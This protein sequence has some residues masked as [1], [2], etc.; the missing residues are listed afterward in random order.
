MSEPET[1][2]DGRYIVVDGRRWRATDPTIP[3]NLRVELVKALM[4]ARRRV[5]SDGQ[6]ARAW[7]HDAKMALGERGDP[8]WEPTEDGRRTRIGAV[9][10]TLLRARPEGT[11]CPSEAARVVGADSWREYMSLARDV[12]WAGTADGSLVVLQRGE[13]VTDP[14][15]RGPIRV[16][17][18]TALTGRISSSSTP[19]PAAP[20]DFSPNTQPAQGHRARDQGHTG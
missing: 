14:Q 20:S 7:V 5:R 8:W 19:S 4:A 16:G 6:A 10:R 17:A 2:P 1:T 12:A 3:E 13:P 9:L 15:V 18:G 11:V